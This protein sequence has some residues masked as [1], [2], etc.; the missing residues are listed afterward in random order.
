MGNF[1]EEYL[2]RFGKDALKIFKEKATCCAH[3]AKPEPPIP[4][5]HYATTSTVSSKNTNWATWIERSM[6]KED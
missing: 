3:L 2:A 6:P 1:E 5:K 4:G